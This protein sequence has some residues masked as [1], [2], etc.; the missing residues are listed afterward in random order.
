LQLLDHTRQVGQVVAFD[1]D[2]AQAGAGVLGQQARTSD[3]LPVP[4]EPHSKAWLAG[5]PLMNWWVLRP[6]WS[7]CWSTPIRSDRRMSR[8]TSSGS[9]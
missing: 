4:R 9:R 3:D 8:L 6:S 1:F 5:M 7:R 2:Q